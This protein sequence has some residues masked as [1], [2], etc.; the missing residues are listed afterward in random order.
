LAAGYELLGVLITAFGLN[1]VPFAGPSN[2]LIASSAALIVNADPLTIGLLVALG[3]ASAK[4]IHYLLTFFFSGFLSEKYRKRINATALKLKRW[5]ILALFLV[6]ASPLPDEPVVIPLGLLK[7][8]PVKFYLAFF[9]GKLCITVVGAY[10]GRAGQ[11]LLAPWVSSEVLVI[12]SIVLT[13]ALTVALLK[14]DVEKIAEKILK[15]RIT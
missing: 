13:I 2:L 7:Y 11:Q 12:A 8:N 1:L 15:R 10:L 6:A 14:V 4:S 3:A 9:F 5:A